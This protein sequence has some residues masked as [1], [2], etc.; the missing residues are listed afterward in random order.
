MNRTNEE[1]KC[2][3]AGM[4]EVA[5]TPRMELGLRNRDWAVMWRRGTNQKNIVMNDWNVNSTEKKMVSGGSVNQK[6]GRS[7]NGHGK[8]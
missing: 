8:E 6:T 4:E 1:E 7:K 2:Y 3:E 5:A